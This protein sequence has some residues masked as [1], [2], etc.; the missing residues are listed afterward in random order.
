MPSPHDKLVVEMKPVSK[1]KTESSRNIKLGWWR[2]D[3]DRLKVNVLQI[4][5]GC[6]QRLLFSVRILL[7]ILTAQDLELRRVDF[8][9][10][11]FQVDVDE[12]IYVKLPEGYQALPGAV[13]KLNKAVYW[14]IQAGRF[15]NTKLTVDL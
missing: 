6:L 12:E 7:A 15:W 10:M 9:G 13:G 14:L 11:F 2:K 8:E 1:R 3:F 5:T 4:H